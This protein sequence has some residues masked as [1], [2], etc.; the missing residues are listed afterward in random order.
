MVQAVRSICI[1][2]VCGSDR[3]T[4]TL[5]LTD[6]PVLNVIIPAIDCADLITAAITGDGGDLLA[7][8]AGVVRAVVLENLFKYEM[9]VHRA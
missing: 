4:R 3:T 2:V 6:R 5:F 1:V 9:R 8:T 7:L